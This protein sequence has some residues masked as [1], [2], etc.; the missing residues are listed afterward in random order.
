MVLLDGGTHGSGKVSS[1][2]LSNQNLNQLTKVNSRLNFTV[3]VTGDSLGATFFRNLICT[4]DTTL[5][6]IVSKLFLKTTIGPEG[7][8]VGNEDIQVTIPNGA[9]ND[10][11]EISIYDAADYGAFGENSVSKPYK[12]TG[13]PNDFMKPIKIIMKYTGDLSENSYLALGTKTLDA[14]NNDSSIV[15]SLYSA[16][17]SLGYLISELPLNTG[18]GLS[19]A[20]V[21][22]G[23][24]NVKDEIF[25]NMSSGYKSR[26]TQNFII[27]YPSSLEEYVDGVEENFESIL[28]IIRN[29][30]ATN[31][32]PNDTK[33][34]IVLKVQ[35]NPVERKYQLSSAAWTIFNVS[36][37][38]IINDIVSNSNLNFHTGVLLLEREL[39]YKRTQINST[40]ATWYIYAVYSWME[41]LFTTDD[42]YKNPKY[43][44]EFAMAP[45][46]GLRADGG[47]INRKQNYEQGIGM[48]SV[49]KYLTND[50]RYGK[51]GIGKTF[52]GVSQTNL[53]T[54]SL[55]NTVDAFIFEWWPDFFK[56]YVSGNI[57]DVPFG[58]FL[59]HK[60]QSWNI[61]TIEDTLR[62]FTG[63]YNDLSAKM[64]S[65]N[66]NYDGLKESNKMFF[67]MDAQ[68][69]SDRLALIIFG[70]K[71]GEPE[72]LGTADAQEFEIPNLKSY[73]DDGMKQFLA[74]LVNSKIVSDDYLGQTEIDLTIRIKDYTECKVLMS[75]P[76]EVR[77]YNEDNGDESFK[78]NIMPNGYPRAIGS[79]N[80]NVWTGSFDEGG[81][82]G[83]L[84]I[85]L[86]DSQD[87][88][89]KMDF[90]YTFNDA[91][92]DATMGYSFTDIPASPYTWE[93]GLYTLF[94]RDDPTLCDHV[95]NI[96]YDWQWKSI[97]TTLAGG[98]V[99]DENSWVSVQFYKE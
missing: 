18:F 11:S 83:Q 26:T 44:P 97:S 24:Q 61:T 39:W 51:S 70:V 77:S 3:K 21:P 7:G 59:D 36:L 94:Y 50:E 9:F 53:T 66:L 32:F 90:S 2:K 4:Q 71:N 96:V 99:C 28:K 17:D 31:F 22:Y 79:F 74:V 56:E 33:G 16:I 76:V 85:T 8:T 38:A 87:L 86:N 30:L 60:S 73:W 54:S 19:K 1:Q 45:F 92:T 5:N 46:N 98:P 27:Q 57:Y 25:L 67:S 84:E 48:S 34:F 35:K 93:E 12:I 42:N 29:D 6:L 52:D 82:K 80:G 23:V 58:Y 40:P 37:D 47:N 75:I 49:I 89:T 81:W 69:N 95:D 43:F 68:G 72:Y 78:N 20:S 55:I 13:L 10:N 41:E 88:V 91:N 65:I 14:N 64:F 63:T 62:L 15:Y